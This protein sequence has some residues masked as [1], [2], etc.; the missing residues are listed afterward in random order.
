MEVVCGIMV[1]MKVSTAH[2]HSPRCN[3]TQP[4]F[5]K[6]VPCNLTPSQ[7]SGEL[8]VAREV[9]NKITISFTHELK[10][11]VVKQ[12]FMFYNFIVDK[13]LL[14]LGISVDAMYIRG[15]LRERVKL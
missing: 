3:K 5:V 15:G 7:H 9:I 4:F 8:K 11:P 13:T 2:E 10:I 6:R 12:I 1:T 14:S